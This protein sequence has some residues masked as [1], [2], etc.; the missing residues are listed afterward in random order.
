MYDV[1]G[2]LNPVDIVIDRERESTAPPSPPPHQ[3]E[4]GLFKDQWK[5]KDIGN[6][7]GTIK[8]SFISYLSLMRAAN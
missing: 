8:A 6:V 2:E 3:L 7:W 4:Y 1:R 5:E